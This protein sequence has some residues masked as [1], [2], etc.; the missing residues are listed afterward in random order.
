MNL[1]D[2]YRQV[3]LPGPRGDGRGGRDDELPSWSARRTTLTVALLLAVVLGAFWWVSP[4][5]KEDPKWW[6]PEGQKQLDEPIAAKP[7]DLESTDKALDALS[8]WERMSWP[9]KTEAT[10]VISQVFELG[11][12]SYVAYVEVNR[13]MIR[14]HLEL[15]KK[16]ELVRRIAAD[17]KTD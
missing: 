7:I 3:T 6:K 2:I 9:Q 1:E 16:I 10:R 12:V 11:G 17:E 14:E 8:G 15:R 13:H 4:G 5:Q